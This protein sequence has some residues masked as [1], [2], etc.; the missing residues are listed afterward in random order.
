ML[1]EVR[2]LLGYRDIRG[3]LSADDTD[4]TRPDHIISYHIVAIS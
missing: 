1:N 2:C 4:Q 3:R